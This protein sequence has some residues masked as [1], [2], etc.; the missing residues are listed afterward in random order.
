MNS[1]TRFLCQ[2]NRQMIPYSENDKKIIAFISIASGLLALSCL[3][4]GLEATQYDAEAFANPV[5]LLDMH[6]VNTTHLRWFMLLDLFGYYLLLLPIIFF[7]H[8]KL[9]SKTAWASLFTSLGFGYVFIGAIGAAVLAVLW[10]ALLERYGMATAAMQDVYKAEFLF[11]NDFVVK[12]LWNYLEVLLGGLWWLSVSY[13]V[14]EQ[15]VLKII[16]FVLGVACLVDAF[17][18]FI[19]LSVMAE[20]GLN[21]YLILGIVWPIWIG[22]TVLK[23]KL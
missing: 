12:G 1:E 6:G 10:P 5:K 17:G 2:T 9:K 15:R 20:I 19:Q 7:V 23:N 14:I 16:T 13:F 4:V 8:Q 11:S 18:E 3:L 22:I 21:I